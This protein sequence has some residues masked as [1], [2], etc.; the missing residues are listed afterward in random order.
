MKVQA[1]AAVS[2][3]KSQMPYSNYYAGG[4]GIPYMQGMGGMSECSLS[5]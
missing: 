5:L 3:A 1:L 4:N 2:D